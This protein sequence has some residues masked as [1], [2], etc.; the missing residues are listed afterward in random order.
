MPGLKDDPNTFRGE[1]G[2]AFSGVGSLASA[3]SC[4]GA[5]GIPCWELLSHLTASEPYF[6]GAGWRTLLG[7]LVPGPVE[8]LPALSAIRSST[9]KEFYHLWSWSSLPD[10]GSSVPIRCTVDVWLCVTR[11]SDERRGRE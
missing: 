8:S 4:L 3:A 1:I 10:P 6:P 2:R 9:S 11:V 7:P 5:A